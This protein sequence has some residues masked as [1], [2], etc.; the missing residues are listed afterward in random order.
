MLQLIIKLG[1][2]QQSHVWPARR[3]EREELK[4]N[5]CLFLDLGQIFFYL[6]SRCTL[7]FP[8]S[9]YD[10]GVR[11]SRCGKKWHL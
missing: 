8:P 9:Q 5:L 3:G 2:F 10:L 11:K 7:S 1:S 6:V 4:M